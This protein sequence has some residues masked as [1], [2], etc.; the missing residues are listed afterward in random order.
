MNVEILLKNI[1]KFVI[2]NKNFNF[3]SL[4]KK[5]ISQTCLKDKKSQKII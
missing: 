5:I 3:T 2:K 1:I 4:L